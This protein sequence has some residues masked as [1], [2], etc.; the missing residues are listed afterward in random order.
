MFRLVLSGAVAAAVLTPVLPAAAATSYRV[1]VTCTVPASQQQRQLA[2]NSCM[3][4]LPD[5]TQTYTAHVRNSSGNAIAGVWVQWTDSDSRDAHF[6]YAQN[7]C[8]TGSNGTC[9]AELV[10]THPQHGEKITVKATAGG[11]T[12]T[13]YL[14]FK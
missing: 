1:T 13:G 11:S 7:P 3:N 10:D 5:G 14:T 9:S 6:R 12:G 8:K 2:S 4:Y